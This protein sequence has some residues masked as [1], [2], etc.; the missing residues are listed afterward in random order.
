MQKGYSYAN[1]GKK[2]DWIRS[3][4]EAMVDSLRLDL[5]IA[6]IEDDA[7]AE[8]ERQKSRGI[9]RGSFC[10]SVPGLR[11]VLRN[12]E[13]RETQDFKR[14]FAPGG[15]AVGLTGVH[16]QHHVP[17][18]QAPLLELAET[19]F[20]Q[21]SENIVLIADSISLT[22]QFFRLQVEGIKRMSMA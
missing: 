1:M 3:L 11:V 19:V 8:S 2:I 14:V 9:L 22:N 6:A 21:F 20:G 17:A 13:K 12:E 5:L 10:F 15:R 16:H 18:G 7:A 4:S